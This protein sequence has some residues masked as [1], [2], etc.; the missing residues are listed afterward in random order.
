M[1]GVGCF[2][3]ATPTHWQHNSSELSQGRRM[4]DSFSLNTN[5]KSSVDGDGVAKRVRA[6][7]TGPAPV[8]PETI[9]QKAKCLQYQYGVCFPV[10]FRERLHGGPRSVVQTA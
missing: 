4:E 5:V 6:S 2:S 9:I 3:I 8:H 7:E 1:A 10:Q